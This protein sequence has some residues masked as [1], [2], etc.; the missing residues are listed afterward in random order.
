MH[1]R[2]LVRDQVGARDFAAVFRCLEQLV[3]LAPGKVLTVAPGSRREDR[4]RRSRGRCSRLSNFPPAH[5][6]VESEA[7]WGKAGESGPGD[8]Q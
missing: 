5:H 4:P 2:N 3:H 1:L 8:L 6:F 7:R